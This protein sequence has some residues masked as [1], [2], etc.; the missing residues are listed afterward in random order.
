MPELL[1]QQ[2]GEEGEGGGGREWRE[3][4]I[5]N[6]GGKRQSSSYRKK[7]YPTGQLPILESGPS[8]PPRHVLYYQWCEPEAES[9]T[10]SKSGTSRRE[11][12]CVWSG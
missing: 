4:E 9:A 1:L 3:N 7:D 12:G 2:G 8:P 6:T 10:C 5:I 11:Q